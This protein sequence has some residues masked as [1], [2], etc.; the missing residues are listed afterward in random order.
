MISAFK[1]ALRTSA[2]PEDER[3]LVASWAAQLRQISP[4]RS[5]PDLAEAYKNRVMVPLVRQ[6]ER[7]IVTSPEDDDHIH[8][9]CLY[10]RHDER[11]RAIHMLYVLDYYRHAGLGRMMVD[12]VRGDGTAV[13]THQTR[14]APEF[15]RRVRVLYWPQLATWR[16]GSD[17]EKQ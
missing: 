8:A 15:A 14:A 10:T 7:L 6:A 16:G 1:F 17:E 12:L 11:L 5:Y 13:Y 9:W 2:R 3:L 4:W